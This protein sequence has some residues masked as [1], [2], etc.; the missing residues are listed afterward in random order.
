MTMFHEAVLV[1]APHGAGESNILFSQPG[2]YVI[3]GVCNRPHVN[4][5]YQRT[6]YILGHHYHAV[7]SKG[8]CKGHIDIS[9]EEIRKVVKV[10]VKLWKNENT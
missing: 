4:L 10:H 6:A 3:E 8:G 5:C 7:V 2:T 1:V 9:T